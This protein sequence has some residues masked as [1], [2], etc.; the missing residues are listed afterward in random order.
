[1][2][3]RAFLLL[4]CFGW[5]V[6]GAGAESL[7]I[8][9]K[10]PLQWKALES[11]ATLGV[12]KYQKEDGNVVMIRDDF[13]VEL[14][15]GVNISDFTKKYGLTLV[16]QY[17]EFTFLLQTK[18]A[19]VVAEINKLVMDSNVAKAYPNIFRRVQTR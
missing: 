17:N 15:A 18:S 4:I 8:H 10:Q 11:P 12:N 16:K 6:C 1:M 2:R 9:S 13:F 19:D 5:I 14:N 7:P 3:I